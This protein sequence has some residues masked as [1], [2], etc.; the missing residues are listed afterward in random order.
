MSHSKQATQNSSAADPS[1]AAGPLAELH[2]LLGARL[3]LYR[4]VEA[5]AAYGDEAAE[6]DALRQGSGLV[7]C[8]WLERIEMRGEDRARFLNGLVTCDVKSLEP[9]QG[10]Y[11]FVTSVKGRVMADVTVLALDDRLWLEL[12]P[13]TSAAVADHLRKYV[14][15]DRVEIS[16]LADRIPLALIGPRAKEALA[17]V[18]LPVPTYGHL[19]AVIHG[20]EVQLVKEP[21]FGQAAAGEITAWTLWVGPTAAREL[22]EALLEHGAAHGLRPVGHRAFDQ[23]RVE[24]GR[25]LHGLDFDAANFPQE[26]GLGD[27]AVSYTK[28]CYLGQEVVARIH[29]RGGVNRHL[30]RLVFTEASVADGHELLGRELQVAGRAVGTV[31]SVATASSGER[32]GLAVLHQRATPGA[33]VEVD[34]GGSARVVELADSAADSEP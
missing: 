22:C 29:Y 19:R 3:S 25:P 27:L 11:G 23:L 16:P 18:T 2:R 34:G 5:A 31:T 30:R 14:I 17:G 33:E 21:S 1:T 12:S 7:N 20:I 28:G 10:A 8:P 32:I 24:A 13:G 9:G 4:G 26:T 6:S 15:V